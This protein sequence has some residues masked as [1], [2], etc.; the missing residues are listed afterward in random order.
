MNKVEKQAK[1]IDWIICDDI[2]VEINRKLMFIGVYQDNIIV[3]KIPFA[4]P[5]FT[6]LTK[7]D[8]SKSSIKDFEIRVIQPDKQKIGP[9][10]GKL[11][12]ELETKKKTSIQVTIAPFKI[13]IAGKYKIVMEI[14]KKTYKIGS[15]E[16]ALAPERGEAK[17]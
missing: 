10:I 15:F 12:P 2:R 16:V 8:T 3:P 11:G 13:P 9:I 4:L 5:Q 6:I 7:W 17:S 1:L 14:D